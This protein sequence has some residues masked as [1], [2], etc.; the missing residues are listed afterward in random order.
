MRPGSLDVPDRQSDPSTPAGAILP[1]TTP[2]PPARRFATLRWKTLLIVAATLVGLIAIIYIPLRIFLLGS[3]ISLERQMLQV[4]LERGS[5]AIA[6]DLHDLDLLNAGYASWDDTYAFVAAPRQE[7]IDKNYYDDLFADNRLN[8]VLIVDTSGKIV[9]GKAFDLN[10]Q[11]EVP[12]PQYFQQLTTHDSLLDRGTSADPISGVLSLPDAPMLISSRPILTSE[13]Q[14]PIRGTLMF[15]RYLDA[16][17]I[18]RLAEITHLTLSVHRHDQP[19]LPADLAAAKQALAGGA[20]VHLLPLDE[21]S[22]AGFVPLADL[23][24]ANNLLLRVVMP[25]SIY[26]QGQVGILYFLVSLACAGLLFGGIML[27]LI[28]RFVL[29]RLAALQQGV[30]RIGGQ[31]D[32]SQ[33]IAIAGDDELSQLSDSINGMLASL[34]RAHIEHHQAEEVRAQLLLREEALRAKREFL[35]IVSHELRTPLTPMLGYLDLMLV[36]EGGELTDAQRKFLST[37]RSNTLRMAV[38]VEDLLEVGRIETNSV[39]LQLRPVD[40]GHLIDEVSALLQPE[41]ER[42]RLTLTQ[43]LDAQLP[44]VKAD[45]KRISQVLMNLLSNAVKYSYAGGRI[46]ITVSQ[47]DDQSIEVQIEDTGVGLTPE[48]LSQLFTPFYRA[49]SALSDKVGGTGLGLTIARSFVELHGGSIS[50]H[51][52]VGSGSVFSFR[53]PLEQ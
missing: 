34:E 36:G 52:Q 42:K 1:P 9:F 25:R 31:S 47:P 18:G 40:L 7:Y 19:D 46:A 45:E 15:G 24:G 26:S 21:Q 8:L 10:A 33:R 17:E 28:E 3:F 39:K 50:V 48:Q 6:D 30:Q 29:S 35:S 11:Q 27:A 23:D 51:S 53:L 37:I 14:G 4:D 38:L 16:R 20:P 5:D 49:D 32:L 13:E 43:E 22:I 12:V 2:T 44:L 41:L